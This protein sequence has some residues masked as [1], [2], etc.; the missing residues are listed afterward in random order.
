[1]RRAR[2][3]ALAATLAALA[4]T[5]P[6]RTALAADADQPPAPRAPVPAPRNALSL[7]IVSL[8]E[9]GLLI[10]YERQLLPRFSLATSM[11][12]RISGGSDYSVL[13][14]TFG[15]EGRYWFWGRP[16][17]ARFAGR[18]MVGPFVSARVDF[19][20]V[21]DSEGG[22]PLGTSMSL[23]EGVS[24]G[25]RVV[26]WNRI[27]LTPSFGLGMRTDF[28]PHG[29]LA[30]WTRGELGRLALYTGVLF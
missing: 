11:A 29:R 27:E 15:S 16:P 8:L 2:A 13:G 7:E 21:H 4:A 20:I 24:L 12:G 1:M 5:G 6:G 18:A 10:Q 22:H 30:P 26:F 19:G 25:C 23:A 9:S 3:K 17:F 28:D 14:T